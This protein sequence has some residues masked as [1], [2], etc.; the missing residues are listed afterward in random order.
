MTRRVLAKS[1]QEATAIAAQL[2][3]RPVSAARK[4]GPADQAAFRQFHQ[5]L[6][7]QRGRK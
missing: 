2:T 6:K 3:G 1:L 5:S 4:I 7:A